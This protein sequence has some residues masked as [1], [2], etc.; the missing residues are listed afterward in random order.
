[1]AEI[2][3]EPEKEAME[4]KWRF[5]EAGQ[6]RKEKWGRPYPVRTLK[7]AVLLADGKRLQGHL[8]T[9]ALYVEGPDGAAK[10]LLR[11]KD[12]GDEGQS[13]SDIV[14]PVRVAF[15]DGAAPAGDAF[16]VR[17]KRADAAELVA[18]TPGALVRLP[19]SRT[20]AAGEF[21]FAGLSAARPFMA[22][23]TASDIRVGW[24]AESDTGLVAR[25]GAALGGAED[26]FDSKRLLGA[27]RR[28]D[29]IY[30]LLLLSRKGRTTLDAA[31]SLP[32]RLEIWRWKE[33][34]DGIM[35]AGRGFFFR[36]I[37]GAGEEPPPVV[38]CPAMESVEWKDGAE[39]P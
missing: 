33:N 34:D 2:R 32:W 4:Q 17:V 11:A 13:F 8:Y 14:Y 30:S 15:R 31:K 16:R 25:V 27:L 36:G 10:V 12:R 7:A 5:P 26:F 22:V 38:L 3:F 6:T 20:G 39:L 35:I 29:D 1:V 19:A 9:A 21:R 37:L 18:L 28:G 23:R 24:P